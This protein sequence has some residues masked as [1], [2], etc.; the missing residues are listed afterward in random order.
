L[1]RAQ[2]DHR[3]RH[4]AQ[5]HVREGGSSAPRSYVALGDSFTAGTGEPSFADRLAAMLREANPA[6]S[7]TN[8]AV[9]GARTV[10]V[11]DSQLGAALELAPDVVTIVCGGN[12]A[13]LAVRPDVHAH[14]TAFESTLETLRSSLPEAAVATATTPDP[15]RFLRLRPRSASRI[16][17]AIE[18]INEAT[19]AAAARHGVPCLD[20]AAHPEALARSNYSRDGYHPSADAH[21]RAAAAFARVIGVRLGIHLD[22]QEVI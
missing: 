14:M 11:A 15:G 1:T 19:R 4:V 10:E 12:D 20:I 2:P 7:Y 9:Q 22:T 13:L 21:R 17:R 5:T 8:L 3:E 6:L 16:T 18:R